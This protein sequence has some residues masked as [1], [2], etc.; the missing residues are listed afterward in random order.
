MRTV[1]RERAGFSLLEALIAAVVLG[2][3]L[4]GLARLH[5][6]S[7]QG[8]VKSDDVGRA[9]EVARGMAD[10]FATLPWQSLPN[11]LPG[12]DSPAGWVAPPAPGCSAA[13][14]PTQQFN[15]N[16]WGGVNC[17]AWYTEDGVPDA[18]DAAWVA[19]PFQG[20]GSTPDTG[21]FLVDVAISQHPNQADFPNSLAADPDQEPVQVVWVWV[22]W[23]DSN[24]IVHEVAS[25]RV[26]TQ[27]F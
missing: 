5:I 9:A 3:G 24:N 6:T 10:L 18:N 27:G 11:C 8:T 12:R 16:P 25:Q 21:N 15:P 7:I 13:L 1:R 22:C 17:R 19:N 4:V 2:V 20:D 14:G 23:R 26:M